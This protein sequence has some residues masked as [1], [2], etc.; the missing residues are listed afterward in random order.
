MRRLRIL[1][2]TPYLPDPPDFGGAARMFHL[3]RTVAAHHEVVVLS[4]AG[5]G[6]ASPGGNL[7]AR[8][9]PVRVPL[10][11]RQPPD[12]RKRL[13]QVRSLL[14]R[15][16]FQDALYHHPAMQAA[17]DRLLRSEPVDLVQ[18]EF[19]QM[20]RY[21]LPPGVPTVLDVH[22]VE[23][24]VL[25]QAATL[26]SLP[27]R[28]FNAIE[29]RK[30]RRE[31][32]AAWRRATACVATSAADAAAVAAAT[33]REV[34]VVPN[35]VDLDDVPRLPLA[36]TDPA[37]LVFVGAMRYRPNADAARWFVEAVFPRVRAALPTATLTIVGADPPPDVLAL[38]AVPGVQVTGTVPTV[39]PWVERAG[40][41]VVPL[42]AGG[43]TRLK[44]LEAF[45]M[46][47]PVV[48]TRLGAAGID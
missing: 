9:I 4:L 46:G 10:T 2:V 41:V 47:R 12:R 8:V 14:S 35:G 15:H 5:P 28:L 21:R 48:S 24:D 22:N 20:G 33:G 6:E 37:A 45:A 32:I 1:F 31:E 7:S 42:R 13:A 44:I 19:A 16:S 25:R 39:R 43:G 40:T 30:F 11:A 3:I 23:H 29:Y 27:R 38:G 26:G 34:A 36:G 17:L 18:L